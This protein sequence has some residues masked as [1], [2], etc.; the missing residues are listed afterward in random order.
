M[1]IGRGHAACVC[2]H[3]CTKVRLACRPV[4]AEK[5]AVRLLASVDA[6]MHGERALL[7]AAVWIGCLGREGIADEELALTGIV[8]NGRS[9]SILLQ[10]P[11]N[12]RMSTCAACRRY[13]CGGA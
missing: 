4:L 5:A 3:V 12:R 13:A 9:G 6:S 8:W 10:T 7:G 11:Y 2:A 1:R